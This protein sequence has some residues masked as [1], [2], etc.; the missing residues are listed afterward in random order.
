M[1]VHIFTHRVP[2]THWTTFTERIEQKRNF[3]KTYQMRYAKPAAGK[4][5][6]ANVHYVEKRQMWR[7]DGNQHQK[8][9]LQNLSHKTFQK[10]SKHCLEHTLLQ[11]NSIYISLE[12]LLVK[13]YC[14]KTIEKAPTKT[15]DL[16]KIIWQMKGIWQIV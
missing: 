2:Y 8:L 14:D 1:Y 11:L 4:R 10:R 6:F 12:I 5:I 13:F 16:M 9:I 15:A 7:L 3:S